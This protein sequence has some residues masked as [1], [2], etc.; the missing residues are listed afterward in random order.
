MANQL[1]EIDYEILE[2]YVRATLERV[3]MGTSTCSKGVEDLM[4][5]L[6]A[7]DNGSEQ[8]FIPYMKMMLEK[9]GK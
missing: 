8:E 2:R 9:W 7:R 3:E 4:H 5:P 6:T 1:S